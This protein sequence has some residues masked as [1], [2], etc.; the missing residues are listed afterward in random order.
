MKALE[1]SRAFFEETALPSL[2]ARYP[3]AAAVV[4]AGLVGNGSECFGYDDEWS[5]DHDWGADFFLWLPESMTERIPGL[6]AW[7]A[8]L[9]D[10][11]P[12]ELRKHP[13][14][15][16][17]DVGVQT[18]GGFY[19]SLIGTADRPSTLGEWLAAPEE[20]LAM[21]VNGA[22][23][24]DPTGEF[25]AVRE[26]IAAHF[27]EDVRRKRIAAACMRAAQSGQY[28]VPRM[29][30]RQD[31]VTVQ[32]ALSRFTAEATHL[33]FLLEKRYMPYYKWAHRAL[34][35]LSELGAAVADR[36]ETMTLVP[37]FD[38]AALTRRQE[39]IED[40]CARLMEELRRQRLS[41]ETDGFLAVHGE[42]VRAR[43]GSE[44]LRRLPA[45]YDPFK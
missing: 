27:P 17:A 25:T 6:R 14:A 38:P 29:A 32:T 40:I 43:I 36:L 7:K 31:W 9:C 37:G 13:S 18:V 41:D 39:L 23:F 44:T 4:A 8:G 45:E 42:A 15:Y 1:L 11:L 12:Q 20:N 21:C 24:R 28:N 19:Q 2:E 5:R 34:R 35:E 16:G 30:R 22:V 33:C 10:A 26:R 3:E